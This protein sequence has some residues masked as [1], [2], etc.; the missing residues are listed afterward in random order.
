MKFEI[1]ENVIKNKLISYAS[2]KLMCE[3]YENDDSFLYNMEMDDEVEY[4]R[5]KAYCEAC[6]EWMRAIG[7]HPESNFVMEIIEKEKEGR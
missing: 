1:T 4:A 3:E 6:E 2:H 5:H 7:I